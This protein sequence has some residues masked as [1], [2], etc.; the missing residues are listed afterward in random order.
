MQNREAA[1]VPTAASQVSRAALWENIVF[2]GTIAIVKR[3]LTP[4]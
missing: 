2:G 3:T 1:A 4:H